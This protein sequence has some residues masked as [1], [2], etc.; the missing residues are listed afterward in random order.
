MNSL[1]TK[2]SYG[3]HALEGVMMD[4]QIWLRGAQLGQPLGYHDHRKLLHLFGR[5]R[6]EFSELEARKIAMPTERGPQ[7]M[8]MFSLRGS[9]L[10]ALLA[11]TQEGKKFRRWVLDVLEG[12]RQ[13]RALQGELALPGTH[14][15][16][17]EAVRALEQA[18]DLIEAEHPAH[19]AIGQMID[20]KMPLADDP[21]L[22]RLVEQ[23]DGA[24]KLQ[25]EAQRFFSTIR[26]EAQRMGYTLE[27]V[28]RAR[29]MRH[30]G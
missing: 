13:R 16:P 4:G 15:L 14:I 9:E 29:R 5:Y 22:D 7:E 20:G 2:L 23:Y 10:L 6:D 17:M 12:R 19:A 24:H 28:K 27:A 3:S 11:R 1:T 26:R 21:G 18:R 8:W 30:A 25:A